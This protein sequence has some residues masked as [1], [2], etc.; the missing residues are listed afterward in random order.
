MAR[1]RRGTPP[2]SGNSWDNGS[3]THRLMRPRV[4]DRLS[5]AHARRQLLVCLPKCPPN[6][7]VP[8]YP[9]KS[10]DRT[11]SRIRFVG[12]LALLAW[13]VVPAVVSA[14]EPGSFEEIGKDYANSAR[15]LL[16]T[17]CLKCHSTERQEGD[18][19]L[20]RFVDLAQVR[21][22]P[23]VWIKVAEMLDNGEMPPKKSKQPSVSERQELRAWVDRYLN[24][25]AHANAGDPGPV[26]L[27]RLSNAEYNYTVRDLTHV[28]LQPAR[29]FP[30]DGAA[31][32]GFTNTGNALV[33]SPALIT[34]YLDA[35]REI[36]DHAVL[37]PDG[38]RF[39]PHNTRRDWT[40]DTLAKIRD[41][42]RQFTDTSGGTRVNLQGIISDT[43]QG[44][45]LPLERYITATL[46]EREQLT[47]GT[48]TI[49]AAAKKHG[50]NAK[51]LG[52]LWNKLNSSG[53]SLVIDRLRAR[54]RQAK[55]ENAAALAADI[56]AWQNN[57]WKFGTVGHIGK[58]GGPKAWLE[59]V[60]P[61]HARQELRL[62]IPAVSESEAVTLALVVTDAGDGNEHDFVVWE[63][64]RLVAPGR[65][66]L[67]LVD[68][69]QFARDFAVRRAQV[70]AQAAK[71]LA[72]ADDAAK[73]EGLADAAALAEKYSVD[74]DALR[75]W[76]D[77][78]GIG[79]DGPPRIEGCLD[80]KS[81]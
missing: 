11:M 73:R 48:T 40:D 63:K 18:L 80:R 69:R 21:R 27:R 56:T 59:P 35:A 19:D 61:L 72:A 22:A 43:N 60:N 44:G 10:Q 42:Y 4:A 1:D 36:A 76:L 58:V 70:F 9:H 28:D 66:D 16:T 23:R 38:M 75:A 45:R 79:A 51:Y 13:L 41:F 47:A 15:P 14:A 3:E 20:E 37:L 57:L 17:F 53:P 68:V 6:V 33:M 55:P 34:K 12:L 24:A 30:V 29:D 26:V 54:W 25:E 32:E 39:S 78:L 77:Y 49:E 74:P 81:T 67:L 31:G 7:L 2:L 62:K 65:P 71:Y 50:L 46:V 52:I 5:S 64:P 8:H